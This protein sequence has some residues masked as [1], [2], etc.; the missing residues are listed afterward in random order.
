MATFCDRVLQEADGTLSLIRVFDRYTITA[1]GGASPAE[2]PASRIA[3]TLV[4]ALKAGDARGRY[5]L[6]V[7]P[8]QPS[9]LRGEAQLFDVTFEGPE[10]GVQ[11]IVNLTIEAVEGLHWFDVLL[12][13]TELTRIPLRILYQR[14]TT[15]R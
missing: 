8:E 9:G 3:L 15:R 13:D 12:D 10:R 1:T 2:L 4:V 6:R 5:T 7:R 11:L 14:R